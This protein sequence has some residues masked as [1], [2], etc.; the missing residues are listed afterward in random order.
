[1]DTGEANNTNQNSEQRYHHLFEHAPISIFIIDLTVSPL[2][3]LEVNRRAELVYGYPAVEL[4]GMAADH[5]VAEESFLAALDMV[6]QVQQGQ[7]VTTEA[8]H[9]RRDGTRFPVCVIAAPDPTDPDQMIAMVED[10]TAQKQQRTEAAAIDA[11]RRRIAH[12]IHDG[13]AQS[14]A[15]LRF[16]AALWTHRAEA[17]QPGLGMA[18]D[19]LLVVLKSTI[20]DLRRSIFALRPLAACRKRSR[21][22]QIYA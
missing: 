2:T 19:E 22:R 7:R 17:A 10:I 18:L 3:I 9:R 21:L 13:V 14:L 8:S 5:L 1:M 15:G 6:Q 16:K 12:E 20:D 11:D 4:V